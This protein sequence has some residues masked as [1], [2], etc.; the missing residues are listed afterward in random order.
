MTL[1]LTRETVHRAPS[2]GCAAHG[3]VAFVLSQF[4]EVHETFIL[5]ELV[6]L[7]DAGLDFVIFSLKPCRD[8][9]IQ[10]EAKRFKGRTFYPWRLQGSPA[11]HAAQVLRATRGVLEWSRPLTNA[12][13]AWAAARLAGAS[14]RLGVSH[15]HAHWATA[16]T[17]A[18]MLMSGIT[19]KPFSFTAHAWDIYA[20][21][22]RLAEKVRAASFVIT[23]T[24][25]NVNHIATA[26]ERRDRG[27]VILN[28]HGVPL[29]A[30]PRTQKA[31]S[32]ILRI[33]A[34]GRLVETK[35]FEHLID[36]LMMADFPFQLVIVGEGPLAGRLQQK[37]ARLGA[38]VVFRGLVPNEEVFEVLAQSDV[39][40]MPSVIARNGDRDGIPNVMLEAMSLGL[41]V[42]ASAI[43][44]IPEAVRD[45]V[46]G[47][48]VPP[49]DK[50]ALL[51]ALR[52]ISADA[53]NARR[54]GAAGR[55]LVAEVFCAEK[56]AAA[57][58]G[59][60]KRCIGSRR[61]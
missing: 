8:S 50:D 60:F 46:T 48:L 14:E 44:G 61:Q 1:A 57:L 30:V 7:D 55:R 6:A 51:N 34:A 19:G 52:R 5:R 35:G 33:A 9:V 37:A 27:K 26:V 12:Y 2:C 3:R 38:R 4:P 39:F 45:G 24:H 59:V 29:G 58:H 41:P 53:Q 20:G 32:D 23:C 42:I 16:P 13:V 11:V 25:A 47:T 21:D 54:M 49:A 28:Y 43:S 18:A 56:N 31:A 40:V 17:S 22:S 15:F 36:A 10:K